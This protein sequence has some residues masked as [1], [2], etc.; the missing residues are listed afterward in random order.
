MVI[1]PTIT[2]KI[3]RRKWPEEDSPWTVNLR[4]LMNLHSMAWSWHSVAWLGETCSEKLLTSE[5]AGVGT[6]AT[7]AKRWVCWG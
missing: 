3:L 2:L 5:G 6:A 7:E 1:M 4:P